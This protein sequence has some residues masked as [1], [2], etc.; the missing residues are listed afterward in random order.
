[1]TRGQTK[2]MK[3]ALQGLILEI[4]GKEDQLGL[5]VATK[6]VTFLQLEN[7]TMILMLRVQ[8]VY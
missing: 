3:Q 1:M 8:M 2:R 7:D 4:R 6:W 5:E